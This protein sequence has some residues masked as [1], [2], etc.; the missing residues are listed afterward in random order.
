VKLVTY[1]Y[2]AQAKKV[3]FAH[4]KS[5]YSVHLDLQYKRNVGVQLA[6]DI[7]ILK[8]NTFFQSI[9]TILKEYTENLIK[10]LELV[11]RILIL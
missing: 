9:S 5:Y 8:K 11:L 10:Y 2:D 4:F 7:K 6:T 1:C 3:L